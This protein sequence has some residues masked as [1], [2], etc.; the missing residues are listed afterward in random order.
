MRRFD[1][2]SI[3]SIID[4]YAEEHRSWYFERVPECSSKLIRGID[5]H[6]DVLLT[7]S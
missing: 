6:T 2:E 1:K 3:F 7:V 5:H 4:M